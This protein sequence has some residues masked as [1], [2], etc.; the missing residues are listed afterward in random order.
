MKSPA[1]MESQSATRKME[2]LETMLFLSSGVT[3]L[4]NR[5]RLVRIRKRKE[6][7]KQNKVEND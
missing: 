7:F 2:K 6:V 4:S 1:R 5:R 3:V